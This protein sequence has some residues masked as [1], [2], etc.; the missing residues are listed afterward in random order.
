LKLLVMLNMT[1]LLPFVLFVTTQALL[2]GDH[3]TREREAVMRLEACMEGMSR[4]HQDKVSHSWLADTQAYT[5]VPVAHVSCP[6]F[7]TV[8]QCMQQRSDMM[9]TVM[10]TNRPMYVA[11]GGVHG[12]HVALPP[13][14]G[15][16]SLLHQLL[17]EAGIHV[18]VV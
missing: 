14:Q 6:T 1:L 9:Y 11:P 17:F 8:A 5:T 13:G 18:H 3:S 10:R 7:S 16:S 15:Q 12:G 2:K 4:S